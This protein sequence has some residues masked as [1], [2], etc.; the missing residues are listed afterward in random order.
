MPSGTV[1]ALL[2]ARVAVAKST[3]F[4]RWLSW[5]LPSN[6]LMPV[7]SRR[8]EGGI[9]VTPRNYRNQTGL[10]ICAILVIGAL[11]VICAMAEHLAARRASRRP[12]GCARPH[13]CAAQ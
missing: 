9:K 1:W 3:A 11:L 6:A 12:G 10:H 5:Y 8:G 2:T 4:C 13:R 7:S